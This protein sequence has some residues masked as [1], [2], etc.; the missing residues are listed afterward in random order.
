MFTKVYKSDKMYM[1]IALDSPNLMHKLSRM[2]APILL[3]GLLILNQSYGAS[4]SVSLQIMTQLTEIKMVLSQIGP[5]LSGIL[6]IVAGIFYAVGQML[7]P[8]KKAQFHTTAVNVLIGAVVVGALSFASA[9]LAI[10][11]THLLNNFTVANNTIS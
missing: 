10:A 4:V 9:S 2:V 3:T 1:D 8:D 11:S 5:A 6:F 7:P